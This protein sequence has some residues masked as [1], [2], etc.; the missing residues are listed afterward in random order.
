MIPDRNWYLFKWI[1]IVGCLDMYQVG[2]RCRIWIVGKIGMKRM[3][4]RT[5]DN[6]VLFA[7]S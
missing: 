1:R 4:V 2:V 3:E 5:Q 6:D 7:K